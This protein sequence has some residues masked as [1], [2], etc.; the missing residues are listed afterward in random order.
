[1]LKRS[2]QPELLLFIIWALMFGCVRDKAQR[3]SLA[4]SNVPGCCET[5]DTL[6]ELVQ[7]ASF[8]AYDRRPIDS[9]FAALLTAE[10][11][12]LPKYGGDTSVIQPLLERIFGKWKVV[13]IPDDSMIEMSLPYRVYE[14]KQ[15]GCLGIALLMLLLAEKNGYPLHGVIIPGHFFVRFDNGTVKR[16]I[17]PN[18]AG[19]ERT[20]D[21]YRQR[22]GILPGS[23]YY[24]LRNLSKK[25]VMGIYWYA[26][27]NEARK[28]RLWKVARDCF[29]TSLHLFPGFPDALGNL[30]LVC[31]EQ[32]DLNAAIALFDSVSRIDPCDRRAI[33]NKGILLLRQKRYPEVDSI[34]RRLHEQ[35][36]SIDAID[37]ERLRMAHDH[38]DR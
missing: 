28:K 21:Y 36:D 35:G 12:T 5:T 13:F 27:G 25:E 32:N 22:Y 23:W 9:S 4:E 18:A 37:L 1:M 30:A 29:S 14:K 11:V 15:G 10:A 8:K 19:I 34:I 17:E 6:I 26:I 16:N 20:N 7:K 2:L 38:D 31:A 24:P 33:R 3:S